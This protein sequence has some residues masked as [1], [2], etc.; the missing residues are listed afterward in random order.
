MIK[1]R[2]I[3]RIRNLIVKI[4]STTPNKKEKNSK[5]KSVLN[6]SKRRKSGLKLQNSKRMKLSSARPNYN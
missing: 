2:K 1:L 4:S 5:S 3:L 6:V